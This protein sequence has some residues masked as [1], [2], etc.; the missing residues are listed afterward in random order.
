MDGEIQPKSLA[1]ALEA[2]ADD[3]PLVVDIRSPRAFHQGHI[4]GSE[5]L[6][7]RDLTGG[8]EAVDGAGH[9]VTVCPH[10]EASVQAARLVAAY[11]GFDGTVESLAGGLSAW[12]G[13]L[14]E[15]DE[16]QEALDGTGTPASA[17]DPAGATDAEDG[18]APSA[19]F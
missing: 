2:D 6:P 5:N 17:S 8:V 7:L 9:V 12:D 3:R 13:P 11:E 4:P 16:A 15:G 19:P 14:T 1:E 18:D 10:G